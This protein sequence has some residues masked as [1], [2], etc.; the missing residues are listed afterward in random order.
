MV[1]VN[2]W[3]SGKKLTNVYFDHFC[4]IW[5]DIEH[6]TSWPSNQTTFAFKCWFHG[7]LLN[8][9]CS[10]STYSQKRANNCLKVRQHSFIARNRQWHLV[11]SDL[12]AKQP[13][14][15]KKYKVIF[16]L[17]F[18]M[19]VK[20]CWCQWCHANSNVILTVVSRFNS[21]YTV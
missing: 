1:A 11:I 7:I 12:H 4:C 15:Y 21:W 3:T 20:R 16:K 18:L 6:T 9:V 2:Q 19:I 5:G 13:G 10:C 17:P 8:V 14:N